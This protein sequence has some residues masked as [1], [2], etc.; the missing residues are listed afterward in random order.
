MSLLVTRNDRIVGIL[1]LVDV[2]DAVCRKIR[3]EDVDARPAITK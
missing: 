1:R 3:R 2:F